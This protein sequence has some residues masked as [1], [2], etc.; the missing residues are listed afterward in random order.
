MPTHDTAPHRPHP[1]FRERLG[2]LRNLPPFLRQIW[3]TS[4][5]LTLT[6]LGL[7]VV[8][9]TGDA[10]RTAR[11][12][13]ARVGIDEVRANVKP[14]EKASVVRSVQGVRAAEDRCG[15]CPPTRNLTAPHSFG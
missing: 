6:S 11:A 9:L 8:M 3:A 2:A 15:K 1:S 13:A 4:R 10:E 7:R 5:V 12:V 14:D